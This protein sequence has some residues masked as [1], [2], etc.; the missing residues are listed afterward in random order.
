M[1]AARARPG[2]TPRLN[3][4][5]NPRPRAARSHNARSRALFVSRRPM[6]QDSSQ[7]ERTCRA[8]LAARTAGP[9][10]CRRAESQ[11]LPCR[12]SALGSGAVVKLPRASHSRGAAVAPRTR[13]HRFALVAGRASVVVFAT[14]GPTAGAAQ[15]QRVPAL[16]VGSAARPVRHAHTHA[17]SLGFSAVSLVMLVAYFVV[18]AAVRTLSMRMIVIVR[19]R[20][21]RDPADEP[22]A[23][24]HRP[25]QLPR[26]R[27]ARRAA[28]PEPVHPRDRAGAAR[29]GLP[30]LHLVPPARAPT[31]RC[32]PRS[33]TRSRCCRC[34][35]AYWVLKLVTV[36]VQPRLHRARVE[37]RQ[38]ARPRPA[39]RRPVRGRQPGLPDVRGRRAS[40]TTSSCWCR[41]RRRSRCCS[42]AA[43]ARPAPMV[44]LAVAVKFTAILLLPFL[45]IAARPSQRRMRVLAGRRARVDPAGRA[46]PRAV[47]ARASEP[48]GPEHAADRL[49]RPEHRRDRARRRRRHAA[50]AAAG[51]RRRGGHRGS[52]LSASPRRTG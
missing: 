30:V 37:V 11:R 46:Q 31:D 47:R 17:L 41:R 20:A 14:A 13:S 16:G 1:P 4:D 19:R 33:A 44:M 26:L 52:G 3:R 15:L 40:T 12:G 35:L 36:L 22:A 32:S 34:R 49:Q 23:A 8:R 43:T 2:A 27:A 50:G 51:Q 18:L 21:A 45:L 9:A 25:V 39:L 48:P 5:P 24:A 6:R 38:A 28:P 29:P 42:R 7:P 10:D